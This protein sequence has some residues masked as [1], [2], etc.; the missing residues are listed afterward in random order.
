MIMAK[1]STRYEYICLVR[2]NLT[3]VC[4]NPM[5]N[6]FGQTNGIIDYYSTI[7][8]LLFSFHC[9][10]HCKFPFFDLFS[11]LFLFPSSFSSFSILL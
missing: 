2:G 11:F 3:V 4:P 5:V 7:L 9:H 6:S 8:H 1:D 10:H